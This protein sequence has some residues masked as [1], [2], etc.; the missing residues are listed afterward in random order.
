[1]PWRQ[2]ALLPGRLP[3][4]RRS[5]FTWRC[6]IIRLWEVTPDRRRYPRER[7][8][9]RRGRRYAFPREPSGDTSRDLIVHSL[10]LGGSVLS[11]GNAVSR[12]PH[13]LRGTLSDGR[14][15][16]NLL[17]LPFC[18]HRQQ[19]AARTPEGFIF[20]VKVPQL[21]THE[22]VLVGCDAD[23]KQF[24]DTMHILGKKLGPIVFQFPFFNRSIFRDR[25]EFLDRLIP[26]LKKLPE[27][28]RFAIEVRNGAWLDAEFANLLRG[29]KIALVLQ[30]RSRMPSP[31]EL[32][33]DP[34]TAE[35]TYIRWLGDR[36]GI[37]EQATTWDK[38]VVDRATELRGWVDYCYQIKKRGVMIYAY[39]NNHYAGHAPATIEQ[40][41]NL[42]H[43]QGLPELNQPV[44]MRQKESLLFE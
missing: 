16:L 20:S 37:E 15:G 1:M 11:E 19:L 40:F 6:W 22:K 31:A 44:R 14:G 9:T 32:K 8:N 2:P 21:I 35:W 43:A 36:K 38:T 17:W 33:F 27:A 5:V 24:L 30:D 13:V 39:A 4:Q 26:F 34:I 25:H 10:R 3:V 28:H 12:L 42:W 18:S 41:R 7:S 23:L 29:H